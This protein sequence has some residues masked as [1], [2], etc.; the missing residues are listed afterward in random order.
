M[1]ELLLLEGTAVRP[2]AEARRRATEDG[3]HRTPLQ[4]ADYHMGVAV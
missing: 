1:N 2:N 3:A 4:V